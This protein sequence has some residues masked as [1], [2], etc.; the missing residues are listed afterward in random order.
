MRPRD[1]RVIPQFIS[2]AVRGEDFTVQGDGQQTRCFC[3]VTDLVDGL[4]RL[5]VSDV[6][7]PVNLGNPVELTVLELVEAVRRAAGG[8]G[9]VVFTERPAGDPVRR[10]PDVSRA[11][12]LLGWVPRVSLADGLVTTVEH[13]RASV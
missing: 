5:A 11:R 8:G 2:Q 9:K 13:F 1:G 12:A 10:C 4:V 3:F 7:E 6:R